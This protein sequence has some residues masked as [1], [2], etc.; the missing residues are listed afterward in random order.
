MEL[1]VRSQHGRLSSETRTRI[2]E[3][4]AV[5]SRYLNPIRTVTVDVSQKDK[6]HRVQLT[7]AGEHGILLRAEEKA[8]QLLY[9][10]DAAMNAVR[11]QIER[12]KGRHWRNAQRHD[13]SPSAADVAAVADTQPASEPAIVRTK[14][15]QLKPMHDQEALEQMELLGHAF[16][17]YRDHTQQV[18]VIY[19][20]ADG[21]H[22]VIITA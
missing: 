16:Y 6:H 18:R 13:A 2:E 10:L 12:Y 4:L 22:A 15:F 9:A 1:V 8:S 11:K 14:A 20:R 5:L 19:R 7:V 21:R 3:K 17:V